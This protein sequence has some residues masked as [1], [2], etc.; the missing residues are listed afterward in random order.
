[1]LIVY[2]NFAAG[3]RAMEVCNFLLAQLG[4]EFEFGINM[5]KFEVLQ[6]AKLSAMAVHDAIEAELIIVA[7]DAAW[8]LPTEV[9]LWAEAWVPAKQ[10]QTAALLALFGN[11]AAD[12]HSS[13]A[14]TSAYLKSVADRAGLDFLASG[15]SLDISSE[16]HRLKPESKFPMP[17]DRVVSRPSPEGW[18]LNE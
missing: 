1:V 6:H 13:I 18:G 8:E 11:E 16:P 4:D 12:F 14:P 9:M 5:W 3:K 15:Q 7:C 2:E 17:F 10:G